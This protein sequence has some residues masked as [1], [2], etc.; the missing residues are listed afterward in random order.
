MLKCIIRD[1]KKIYILP[2]N[3]SR[4]Q[5]FTKNNILPSLQKLCGPL[6]QNVDA[7]V[8]GH[9]DTERDDED[10]GVVD[11]VVEVRHVSGAETEQSVL[12]GLV[13]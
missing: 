13:T 6:E 7:G 8:G 4:C 2:Q 11:G 9:H 5:R 12:G 3:Q 1:L 10:L